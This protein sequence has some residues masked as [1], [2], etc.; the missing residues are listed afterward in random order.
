MGGRTLR[1]PFRLLLLAPLLA[2][3]CGRSAETR[4]AE[5]ILERYRSSAGAKPLAAAQ[6]IKLKL[7]GSGGARGTAEI[8][9]QGSE[10]RERRE[11]AGLATVRGL[12]AGKAFYTDEDGVTRVASEPV[13][14]ELVT[15][16]YFWRRA[17]LFQDHDKE[18]PAL[19]PADEATASVRFG[20]YWGN[21]LQLVFSRRD[22]RLVGV[23]SPG[24][25]FD[26]DSPTHFQDT[27]DPNAPVETDIAWVGLPTGPLE[28]ISAGGGRARFK[29]PFAELP[30]EIAGGGPVV[31][32]TIGGVPVR[33]RV[34]ASASGP[35]WVSADLA[36]KT[37]L[38]FSADAFGRE[39]AG[40][41]E[42]A[43][44]GLVFPSVHLER[45]RGDLAGADAAAGGPLFRETVVEC[46]PAAGR[47]RLHDTAVWAP[48]EG[49]Q[50][51][52][53]DDDGNRPVAPL[54]RGAKEF[55]VVLGTAD[56]AGGIVLAPEAARRLGF[57]GNE[58]AA[59]DLGWANHAFPAVPVRIGTAPRAP[60]WGDDGTLSW[61]PLLDYRTFIDMPRRWIY[62][63]SAATLPPAS[64][65]AS[66]S[67]T[68]RT[69]PPRPAGGAPA[70][71]PS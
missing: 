24:F 71:P 36:K 48:P 8:A 22:G 67:P 40:P 43:F 70:R 28:D 61:Q 16:F 23:R 19:G 18:R 4:V 42:L 21:T 62:L 33:L 31:P 53:I 17:F 7:T 39:V 66:R 58:P 5:R 38:P 65:A 44:D 30:L 54:R 47:L 34:D 68:T 51:F 41:A 59:R 3:A 52:I 26:Y 13:L 45:A 69:A 15:R 46:D 56:P 57:T 14:R 25:R 6:L 12:Q 20:L 27:S 11:S 10:Y 35:V 64:D 55:R 50:R 63:G 9:W 32:A 60:D 2:A 37:G 49:Y 29:G 1:G